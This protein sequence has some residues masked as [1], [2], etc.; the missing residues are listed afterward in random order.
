MFL[1]I[2]NS[3]LDNNIENERNDFKYFYCPNLSDFKLNWENFIDFIF[4]NW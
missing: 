2:R 4:K 1:I 3:V